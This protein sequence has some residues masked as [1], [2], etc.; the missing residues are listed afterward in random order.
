MKW[1]FL[2]KRQDFISVLLFA[3]VAVLAVCASVKMIGFF[4]SSANANQLVKQ[5]VDKNK[6]DPNEM[7]R[8]LAKTKELAEELKKKSIFVA[9][10]PK[11][12]PVNAVTGIFGKE[13]FINSKW[14]KAA[15]KIEDAEIVAIEPTR[16]KIRWNGNEKFFLPIDYVA[17]SRQQETGRGPVTAEADSDRRGRA[18][19]QRAPERTD[20]FNRGMG[21]F[22]NLSEQERTEMRERMMEMR[23]RFENMSDEERQRSIGEMRQRFGGRGRRGN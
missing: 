14:F 11:G 10:F 9:Q 3:F 23:E 4:V 22:G 18:T 12:H 15:E 1:D 2:K 17:S 8:L 19:P 20:R 16:V 5:A 6:V 13:A 7:D 21:R